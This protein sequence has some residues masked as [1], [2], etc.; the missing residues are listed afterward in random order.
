MNKI[1]ASGRLAADPTLVTTNSGQ[2]ACKF[3][4]AATNRHRNEDNTYGTNWY[5]CTA[6]G[7]RA[8]TI[9][10]YFH[11]GGRINIEGDL[12]IRDYVD[13]NGAQRTSV[14]I[15]VSDFDFV[16][17][18]NTAPQAAQPAAPVVQTRPA[19]PAYNPPAPAYAGVPDDDQ[20]PF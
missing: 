7:K 10:K 14:D 19:A 13:K 12:V 17:A 8:E 2:Q 4:L 11:K 3:R 9:S 15:E 20:P 18:A 5:N 6:W 1:F 16:D